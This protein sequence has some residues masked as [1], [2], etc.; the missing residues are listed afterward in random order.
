MR[1]RLVAILEVTLLY[2]VIQVLGVAWRATGV[3]QWELQ[4]LG[5]SFSG[6][7][8]SVGIPALAILL[9]RRKWAEYG[10]SLANWRDNLDIG[11]KA[12]PLRLIPY[13][14]GWAGAQ[15]LKL[16][17]RR[18]GGVWVALMEA[19]ALLLMVRILSRHR[20][21]RSG[22]GNVLV[23]LLLLVL[24]VG[25]ALVVRK[26]DTVVVSTVIW[27]LVFSGFGEEFV[28]R[29]YVQSRLNRAFGRPFRWA[30]IPFGPG[31]IIASL[32]FGLLHAFNRYDPAIGVPSLAWGWALSSA[33]A[34]L[35]FGL[36][37]EKTG[38]LLAPGIAHGLPDA[39]GE[40]LAKVFGWT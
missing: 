13:V 30:G 1:A 14:L 12:Y 3:W 18:L 20:P 22:R 4:H 8:I 9:A 26:L 21:V 28:W 23:T 7:A 35:M 34:G 2:A 39:V 38:T 17:P 11:L 16:D 15:W 37:R 24:P 31:L 32:L 6:M 33:V 29:G 10:V 40:A 25:V 5:W 27:Q 36:I 19:V